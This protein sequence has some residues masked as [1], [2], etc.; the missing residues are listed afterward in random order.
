MSDQELLLK[1]AKLL[2]EVAED[3]SVEILCDATEADYEALGEVATRL[4]KVSVLLPQL[5]ID[6][7]FTVTEVL[8]NARAR[9]SLN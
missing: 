4:T 8:R 2:A 6:V 7:P 3:L 5:G 9:T 1:T